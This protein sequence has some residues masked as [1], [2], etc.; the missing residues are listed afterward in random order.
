MAGQFKVYE[1]PYIQF[2][3][4]LAFTNMHENIFTVC[5]PDESVPALEIEEHTLS[6]LFHFVRP[7]VKFRTVRNLVHAATSSDSSSSANATSSAKSLPGS[8]SGFRTFTR[9]F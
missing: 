5:W 2:A 7:S 8:S 4:S 6:L 1:V 9:A 3:A